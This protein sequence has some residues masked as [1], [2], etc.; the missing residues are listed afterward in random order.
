MGGA[1]PRGARAP[2]SLSPAAG[3]LH[4]PAVVAEGA[5]RA[6]PALPVSRLECAG[7]PCER[8]QTAAFKQQRSRRAQSGG[9]RPSQGV[10]RAAP[11]PTPRRLQA[12]SVLASS[13]LWGPGIL[14]KGPHQGSLPPL[15]RGLLPDAGGMSRLS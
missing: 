12:E 7:L 13:R 11:R 15:P 3:L 1:R 9:S 2:D 5:L 10:R 14:G 4:L 8:P 6:A